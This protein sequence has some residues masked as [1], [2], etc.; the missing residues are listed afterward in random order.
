M[1]LL[2]V[3]VL[4]SVPASGQAIISAHSGLVYF[5]E[6]SVFLD[7]QQIKRRYGRF[8]EIREASV[9]STE[10]GRAEVLLTPSVFLRTGDNTVIRMISSSLS[11]T[12]VEL[13]KGSVIA[14]STDM[15]PDNSV[16]LIYGD[17]QIRLPKKG[18]YRVDSDPPRVTVYSGDAE[19]FSNGT[20]VVV[21]EACSYS[22]STAVASEGLTNVADALDRWAKERHDSISAAEAAVARPA[23]GPPSSKKKGSKRGV[24]SRPAPHPHRTF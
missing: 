23:D 14:E 7:G 5:S 11:D 24:P 15:L 18:T 20:T 22:F 2:S 17:W 4:L 1:L 19:V 8:A 12:R 10:N 3:T 9:L 13:L 6:G 21:N 16:T